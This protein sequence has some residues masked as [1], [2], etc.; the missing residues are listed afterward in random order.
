MNHSNFK[1]HPELMFAQK[2]IFEP[3][4]TR[5]SDLEHEC[6]SQEYGALRFKINN[7][8][9]LFRVAKITPKKIGQFVTIWKRINKGPIM[10]FDSSDP[11]DLVIICVRQDNLRGYF[12]FPQQILINQ[13]IFSH[14]HKDGKRAIRVYPSWDQTKNRQAQTTQRWQIKYF[15][16]FGPDTEK[17]NLLLRQ[18]LSV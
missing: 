4:G 13:K 3:L 7:F 6:E 18:T 8:N 12:V 10:P 17:L 16:E 9:I 15:F 5:F 2:Y 1:I 11:I 14:N